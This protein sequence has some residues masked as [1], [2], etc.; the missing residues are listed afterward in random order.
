MVAAAEDCELWLVAQSCLTPY[1]PMD[2]STS[3]SSVH[4]DSPGKNTGVGCHALFQRIFS[5]QG[6][7]PGLLH[8]RRILYCLSYQGSCSLR[9]ETRII[10]GMA[11]GKGELYQDVPTLH[12]LLKKFWVIFF[13]LVLL[14]KCHRYSLLFQKLYQ[15]Y[16]HFLCKG[17]SLKK[18][19]VMLI[20]L[21]L[22]AHCYPFQAIL[23]GLRI[24]FT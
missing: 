20:L 5:T 23:V 1:D 24:G 18:S 10:Q 12:I 19:L 16:G 7:N 6:L 4:G 15:I 9:E 2:C 21:I 22:A 17:R 14:A 11:Q 13:Q 3:G 8:C